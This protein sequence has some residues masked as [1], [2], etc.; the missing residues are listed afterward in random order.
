[1]TI[2]KDSRLGNAEGKTSTI[3]KH[4]FHKCSYFFFAVI[5]NECVRHR[6]MCEQC[7][8]WQ[9]METICIW[10]GEFWEKRF[11]IVF[12]VTKGRQFLPWMTWPLS[13][14]ESC[15]LHEIMCLQH[16]LHL[17]VICLGIALVLR[18]RK[19]PSKLKNHQEKSSTGA[20]RLQV[21]LMSSWLN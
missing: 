15:V 12:M 1:M 8:E 4:A 17:P 11:E 16:L 13:T 20:E 7:L 3:V 19:R 2:N 10:V 18:D 5:W 9:H 14:V 6:K 21:S